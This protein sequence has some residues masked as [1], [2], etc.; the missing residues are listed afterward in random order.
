MGFTPFALAMIIGFIIGA[1]A[2][3]N[4]STVTNIMGPCLII[5]ILAL[6]SLGVMIAKA[7]RKEN[8]YKEKPVVNEKGEVKQT[9]S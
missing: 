7:P 5:D 3:I 2:G 8:S 9:Q 6:I 4:G 1:N